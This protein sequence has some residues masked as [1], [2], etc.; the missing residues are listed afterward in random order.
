MRSDRWEPPRTRAASLSLPDSSVHKACVLFQLAIAGTGSQTLEGILRSGQKQT[1]VGIPVLK[2][3]NQDMTC[4]ACGGSDGNCSLPS[5]TGLAFYGRSHTSFNARTHR[6]PVMM[7]LLKG[8]VLEVTILRQPISWVMRTWDRFKTI[9]TS[10]FR[11]PRATTGSFTQ[12]WNATPQAWNYMT[13]FF[14]GDAEHF[15][16]D[17]HAFH[18]RENDAAEQSELLQQAL[19]RLSSL[20]FV[21]IWED[22][23]RSVNL[24][25]F[26]MCWDASRLYYSGPQSKGPSESL[27]SSKV[28]DLQ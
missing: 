10:H 9:P 26:S 7:E 27:I 14:A 12:W 11:L 3:V 17:S 21:G 8:C 19:A 25:A 28:R 4:R 22:Y 18:I 13:K 2:T 24:L 15:K 6:N 16:S 20:Q 23:D 1:D 5:M